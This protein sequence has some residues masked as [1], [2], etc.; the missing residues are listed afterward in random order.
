MASSRHPLLGPSLTVDCG[1][2]P[3]RGHACA[4]CMVTAVLSWAAP[5]GE[6]SWDLEPDEADAVG[7]LRRSALLS[8]VD[9]SAVRVV[10]TAAVRAIG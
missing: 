6:P 9:P 7:L 4:D 8:A 5:P 2:C 10:E 3:V 1:P